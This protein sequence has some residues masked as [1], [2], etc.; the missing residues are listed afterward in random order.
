MSLNSSQRFQWHRCCPFTLSGLYFSEP[1][2]LC[3]NNKRYIVNQRS[4][5]EWSIQACVDIW[6]Q[7]RIGRIAALAA[8]CVIYIV[9]IMRLFA[10]NLHLSKLPS[11]HFFSAYMKDILCPM[12][13]AEVLRAIPTEMYPCLLLR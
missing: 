1:S 11:Y 2:P 8:L 4:A 6:H 3:I 5:S 7:N 9:C 10:L 12:D 13:L